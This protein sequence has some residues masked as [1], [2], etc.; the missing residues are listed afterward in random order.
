MKIDTEI[1][2]VVAGYQARAT[3]RVEELDAMNTK[4][5][6]VSEISCLMG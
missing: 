6:R 5:M 2:R 3:A 4:A 1:Q